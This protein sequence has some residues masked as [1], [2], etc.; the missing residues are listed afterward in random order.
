MWNRRRIFYSLD[1]QILPFYHF[2]LRD[3]FTLNHFLTNKDL[4]KIA[5]FLPRSIYPFLGNSLVDIPQLDKAIWQNS[6]RQTRAEAKCVPSAVCSA[7]DDA[8]LVVAQLTLA[9]G[10]CP[11]T[12]V[13]YRAWLP[14]Q[15]GLLPLEQ[16]SEREKNFCYKLSLTIK[17]TPS[18]PVD[19]WC[20]LHQSGHL[21]A[22]CHHSEQYCLLPA[23]TINNVGR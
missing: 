20:I 1:A 22:Y 15:P 13:F 12:C 18:I 8:D 7:S 9:Q 17:I 5:I 11:R 19:F 10:Q 4:E 14:C 2:P 16:L 3:I 23:A 21:S 6:G